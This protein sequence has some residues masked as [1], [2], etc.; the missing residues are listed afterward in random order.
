MTKKTVNLPIEVPEG[1]YCWDG[2][3][4]CEHFDNEGGHPNCGLGLGV[5]LKYE[6]GG[7]AGFSGGVLKPEKCLKLKE[8]P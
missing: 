1:K 6:D 7:R 2:I 3:N 4:P 5:E 8:Q